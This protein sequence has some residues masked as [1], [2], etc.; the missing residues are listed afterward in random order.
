MK[1]RHVRAV[2]VLLVEIV[3]DLWLNLTANMQASRFGQA[4]YNCLKTNHKKGET[5]IEFN[6]VR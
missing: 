2:L 5:S 4:N 6:E 3:K 1:S